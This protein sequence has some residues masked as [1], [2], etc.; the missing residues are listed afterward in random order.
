MYLDFIKMKKQSVILEKFYKAYKKI[1]GFD[2]QDGLNY[3]KKGA[4]LLEFGAVFCP[5]K[6]TLE[7]IEDIYVFVNNN[8]VYLTFEEVENLKDFIIEKINQ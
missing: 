3:I 1:N 2:V 5:Y 7:S 6:K 4:F 8:E